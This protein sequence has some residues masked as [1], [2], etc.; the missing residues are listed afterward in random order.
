MNKVTKTYF[1]VSKETSLEHKAGV[2]DRGIYT[3]EFPP[4]LVASRNSKWIVIEECKATMKDALVGDV[5]LPNLEVSL[6]P[7]IG[8]TKVGGILVISY[9]NT[10]NLSMTFLI[11]RNDCEKL[12]TF[13]GIRR[14][15]TNSCSI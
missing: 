14:L 7:E 2:P 13:F 11:G 9:L 8:L 12:V 15:Q 10:P 6:P 1:W 4:E 3:F 5:L